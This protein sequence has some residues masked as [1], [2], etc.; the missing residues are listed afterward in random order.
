MR[1]MSDEVLDLYMKVMDIW[2]LSLDLDH[3]N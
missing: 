2:N 1:N 3:L